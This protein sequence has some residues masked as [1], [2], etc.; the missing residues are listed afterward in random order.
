MNLPALIS[1]VSA[2]HRTGQL[3]ASDGE[4]N[5]ERFIIFFIPPHI[6]PR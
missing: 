6:C 2:D 3:A 5:P 1:G 4:Y